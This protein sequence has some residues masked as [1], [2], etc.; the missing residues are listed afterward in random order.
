LA[1]SL[2]P[3]ASCTFAE[4][5]VT[6]S[7]RKQSAV[8][9]ARTHLVAGVGGLGGGGRG[10]GLDV[11]VVVLPVANGP[12]STFHPFRPIAPFLDGVVEELSPVLVVAVLDDGD[13][14]RALEV[15]HAVLVVGEKAV[16]RWTLEVY[17]RSGRFARSAVTIPFSAVHQLRSVAPLPLVIIQKVPLTQHVSGATIVTLPIP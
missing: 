13:V 3:P 7:L 9:N 14:I 12:A 10:S 6:R 17:R 16:W 2:L 5:F 1:T 15:L 8:V 4:A 11:T